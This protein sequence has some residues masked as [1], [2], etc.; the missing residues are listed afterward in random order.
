M[1]NRKEK[2]NYNYLGICI[3]NTGQPETENWIGIRANPVAMPSFRNLNIFLESFIRKNHPG[4]TVTGFCM[5]SKYTI[6]TDPEII[7][8]TE[9]FIFGGAI[10]TNLF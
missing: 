10:N 8:L 2:E 1:A 7:D 5:S 6:E 3:G 4:K 9:N